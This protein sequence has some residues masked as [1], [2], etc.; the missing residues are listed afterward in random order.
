MEWCRYVELYDPAEARPSA[1][2]APTRYDDKVVSRGWTSET[3]LLAIDS[4]GAGR[5]DLLV[6]SS[7]RAELLKSA[8]EV[9]KGSGLETLKDIRSIAA[10]DFDND[11]LTD[12]CVVTTAGAALYHNNKGVFEKVA[13]FPGT[14]GATN[15]LWL[16]FDH[17]YDLDLLLFGPA[18]VLLRNDGKN[19]FEDQTAAFPFVKGATLDAVTTAMRS[20]TAA[21]DVV[22]SYK[23]RPGVL[24]RDR[25]NGVFEAS[26]LALLP[27]GAAAL[28]ARDFNHDGFI[29]LVSSSPQPLFLR[30]SDERF[31]QEKPPADAGS[32]VRADFNGDNREDYASVSADARLFQRFTG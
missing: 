31:A 14:A 3:H 21:R 13:D 2:D 24:Y 10:G 19:K 32:R 22:A 16:D 20:D 11:G 28:D 17:D 8:T 1:A 23:D 27:A 4:A 5:A 18:P 29:D 6:W 30:N 26:D 15:A 12:L 9:V 25:L 7:A